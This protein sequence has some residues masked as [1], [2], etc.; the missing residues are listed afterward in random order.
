MRPTVDLI[1]SQV[2]VLRE[3]KILLAQQLIAFYGVETKV[4]SQA[5][6]RNIKRF[7][8]DFMFQPS[9]D[10]IEHLKSQI[11]TLNEPKHGESVVVR[12]QFVTLNVAGGSQ[13]AHMKYLHT[14][15]PNKELQCSHRCLVA[16]RQ[17]P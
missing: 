1:T 7:P 14:P 15:L 17:L 4:L 16:T 2:L 8:A 12:S 6:K 5:A 10:D 13:G 3:Q 11:V 9:R